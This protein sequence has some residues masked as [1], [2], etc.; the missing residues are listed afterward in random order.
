ML[1]TTHALIK[2]IGQKIG[3]DDEVIDKLIA[4]NKEHVFDINL[5]SGKTFKGY[6][7]QHNNQRG[8]YKGGIRFHPEVDLDEVRALA[9]LMSFKTAAVGLPLGGGKGG[10]SVNPR[11][12]DD[13]ELEELSRKYAAHLEPHIGPDKDVPAP[14]VN[15]DARIID[16]MV[17][18][19]EQLTGDTTKASF[20][21][22]RISNGGSEGREA[23]TG[24]GGVIVLHELL[25]HLG[26]SKKNITI[27]VQ[28]FGNVGSFFGTISEKQEPRWKL[29][30]ASDSGATVFDATGLSAKKLRDFKKKRGRFTD[31]KKPGAEI[32]PPEN[33][34]GLEVDVLVLAA[35]GDVITKS[36]VKQVKAGCILELANGPVDDP[37]YHYL[38]DKGVEVVPDIIANSG[39]VIVSYLEWLQN[40]RSEHW[41]EDKVNNQ[42]QDYLV[43]AMAELYKTATTNKISLK[44]AAFVNALKNLTE[45]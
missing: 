44:E 23:A 32:R 42:L 12:L 10:V 38:K 28:G 40:R 9:T 19:Y 41:S 2:D 7:V 39:G 26:K 3:L 4:I 16:W 33:I 45:D 36:N 25:K 13:T 6:R 18:E 11:D 21:G 35:L 15:T 27:A 37:A 1:Q 34:I 20:T 29:V 30:A 24:N 31:Y 14:D 8:P 5:A 17:D 43:K 22:K